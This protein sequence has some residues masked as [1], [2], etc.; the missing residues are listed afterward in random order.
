MFVQL[1][2]ADDWPRGID[3]EKLID[4]MQRKLSRY[5]GVDFNFSQNIQDNVEKPCPE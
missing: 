1:K 3:K 5:P 2:P 4:Q